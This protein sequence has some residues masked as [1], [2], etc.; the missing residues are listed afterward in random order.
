MAT[1]SFVAELLA[2]PAALPPM[3]PLRY[4]ARLLGHH[5]GFCVELRELW[6]GEQLVALNQQTFVVIK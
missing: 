3:E 5:Q 4:R 6:H 1:V 2:D